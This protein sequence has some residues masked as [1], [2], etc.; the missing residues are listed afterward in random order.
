MH[1]LLKTAH[2]EYLAEKNWELFGDFQNESPIF[3]IAAIF[4]SSVPLL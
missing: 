2:G 3:F 1:I 4:P